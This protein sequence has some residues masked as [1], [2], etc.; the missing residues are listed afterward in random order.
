MNQVIL[1]IPAFNEEENIQAVV[2]GL[3]KNYPELDYVVVNDGSTDSTERILRAGGYNHITLPVNLGLAGSFQ[4]GMKYAFE[5]GYSCAVQFDGDGQHRAEYVA[6]MKE[7]MDEGYS[8]VI[9]SRFVNRKKDFSLRMVGSRMIGLAI[10]LT[11]GARITDPTSGMRMFD[12]EMMEKF[13]YRMNYG[14]EP[15]TI[16]LLIRQGAKVAEVPVVI[17]ERKGGESYL[18]PGVAVKYMLRM[19]TS[20]L[21]IQNFRGKG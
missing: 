12:R 19:L 2:E 14:P 20:I 13:A 5:K 10:W 16:S 15:D 4:T 1:I 21:V 3:I 9:G 6:E 7:K 11:T 17:D 18:K 8:I